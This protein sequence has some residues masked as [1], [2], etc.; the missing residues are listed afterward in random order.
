MLFALFRRKGASEVLIHS[1]ERRAKSGERRA[2]L[3]FFG[4]RR[5]LYDFFLPVSSSE[6]EEEPVPLGEKWNER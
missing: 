4:K 2:K 5:N 3:D 1:R 6:E